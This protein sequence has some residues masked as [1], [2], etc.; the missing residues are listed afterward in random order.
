[1]KLYRSIVTVSGYT[2]ISRVLG[3]V[4]DMLTAAVIGA[5]PV[6][7]A[8][9]VAFRLPN[10][11]RS[12]FA[13][14]AFNS[15]FVPLFTKNLQTDGQNGARR[16]AEE[17]L[18]VL[19]TALLIM[20][21]LA[22]I[23][24]PWLVALIAPGFGDNAE[25][26]DLAVLLTRITFPYLLC[27][28]LTALSAGILNALGRF[29]AAAA[30]PIILNVVLAAAMILAFSLG[31][32]DRP[33]AAIILAWAVS[34]A[35]FAQLAFLAVAASRQDMNLRFRLPRLTPQI[36]RL[37]K[38]ALP[39]VA[40]AG[41]TQINLFI[42]TMIASLAEGAV[43][44]L[45]YAD[46]INQLPLG[47]VGIAIGVVLLPELSAKLHGGDTKAAMYSHNRS[48]EFAL[49]LTVP[50]AAALCVVPG[51]IIQVLF[52]RGA[53]SAA[54][55]SA[56]ATALAAFAVGLPASVLIRVFL[57]G[58]FAR[59][60]TSTPMLFAGVSAL[61]NIL[62]SLSLFFVIGHVGI[63][64]ATSLAA[65]TYAIMLGATLIRRGHFVADAALKRRG[66]LIV[67][68]SAVMALAL[69]GASY[70]LERFFAPVNGLVVQMLA[71]GALIAGGGVVY[72]AAAQATGAANYR[73]L[74]RVARG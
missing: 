20:T 69:W 18:A 33:E 44:Y 65:W 71:L 23:F 56:V 60:D 42:G 53:F 5:G 26:F 35:G 58:F 43:S 11:F 46:R 70:P 55:T 47:I 1:M 34:V 17:A 13:E 68:A 29:A 66:A 73:S 7:D 39:G 21:A 16:F 28:S 32:K 15:A 10:L 74:L 50:A 51:P 57:P 64:I 45:Y 30:A 24:M 61:V 63:A 2:A 59:E 40:T 41:I 25:K 49:L 8:F 9:F 4:R 54:D 37:F 31:L 12:L 36:K 38:L 3:F 52:Q 19:L 62:G 6:A 14:G 48:L 72:L 67:L 22:E 27:M